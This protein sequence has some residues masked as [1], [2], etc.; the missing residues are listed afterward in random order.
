M[1]RRNLGRLGEELAV[2]ELRKNKY[3][4][5]ER[6]FRTRFG[7]VDIIAVDRDV[8]VLVEVKTRWSEK[9]GSPEEAITP[10]KLRRISKTGQYYQMIHSGLPEAMRI[11]AVVICLSPGGEIER[12]EI[13][14]NVTA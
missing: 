7:E 13:I 3:K 2:K 12:I 5:L 14:E 4:I 10:W 8:L 6:N 1:R 11:D 9:F